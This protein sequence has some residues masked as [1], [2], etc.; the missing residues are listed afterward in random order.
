MGGNPLGLEIY[1]LEKHQT[2]FNRFIIITFVKY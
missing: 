2:V 1:L